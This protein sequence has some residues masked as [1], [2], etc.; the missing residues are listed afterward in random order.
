MSAATSREYLL[1]PKGKVQP[2]QV[3]F[4]HDPSTCPSSDKLGSS[5][6]ALLSFLAYRSLHADSIMCFND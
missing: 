5:L 1:V 3:P 2:P 6:N 4:C